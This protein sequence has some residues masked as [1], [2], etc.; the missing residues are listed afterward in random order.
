MALANSRLHDMIEMDVLETDGSSFGIHVFFLNLWNIFLCF[1][2]PWET[3]SEDED[4]SFQESSAKNNP[5]LDDDDDDDFDF[6]DWYI[7]PYHYCSCTSYAVDFTK[8]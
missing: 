4:Y 8:T 7:F 6:Y 3:D 2:A 5:A 1:S